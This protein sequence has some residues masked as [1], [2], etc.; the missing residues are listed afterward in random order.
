MTRR[1]DKK[2]SGLEPAEYDSCLTDNCPG[3]HII[4]R[5]ENLP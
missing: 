3:F 1:P 2:I 5:Q 4:N